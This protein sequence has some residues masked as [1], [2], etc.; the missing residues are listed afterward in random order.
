MFGGGSP[1]ECLRFLPFGS[2]FFLPFFSGGSPVSSSVST[3]SGFLPLPGDRGDER[4]PPPALEELASPFSTFG[5]T[6]F[7]GAATAPPALP[8]RFC[9]P[10]CLPPAS[11]GEGVS[12]ACPVARPVV[13]PPYALLC[14]L[15]CIPEVYP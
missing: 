1:H 4:R 13:H 6:T 11:Q 12:A 2:S 8:A 15:K 14:V 7:T 5:F 9:R 3:S 10:G